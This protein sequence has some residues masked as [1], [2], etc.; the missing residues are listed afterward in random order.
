MCDEE[1]LG[2]GRSALTNAELLVFVVKSE[3]KVRLGFSLTVSSYF[4]SLRAAV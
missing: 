2:F 1:R 3:G 4:L